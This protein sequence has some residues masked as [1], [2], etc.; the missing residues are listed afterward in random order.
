MLI[1]L[2]VMEMSALEAKHKKAVS[3]L[4]FTTVVSISGCDQVSQG[5]RRSAPAHEEILIGEDKSNWT[6][7]TC[8][9]E[10][11]QK[12]SQGIGE[13]RRQWTEHHLVISISDEMVE[14]SING[15]RKAELLT[16][17]SKESHYGH[18]RV[19][20]YTTPYYS[21]HWNVGGE[22]AS[23]VYFVEHIV[24]ARNTVRRFWLNRVTLC[25]T[26]DS[27][28][29]EGPE[30]CEDPSNSG[31]P[32]VN[33]QCEVGQEAA[34]SLAEEWARLQ[35]EEEAKWKVAKD[36]ADKEWEVRKKEIEKNRQI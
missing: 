15:A 36:K 13:F 11:P 21:Q 32:R 26:E 33:L 27:G 3:I 19:D 35:S 2:T 28:E 23:A 16:F 29:W 9:F 25:M 5:E 12:E 24:I 17:K 20:Y 8:T 34:S 14:E 4:L 10:K 30:E 18:G 6:V 31:L 7:L 22:D 1:Q